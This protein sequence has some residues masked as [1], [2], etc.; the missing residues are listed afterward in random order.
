MRDYGTVLARDTCVKVT[1]EPSLARE[2]GRNDEPDHEIRSAFSALLIP[3]LWLG[4]PGLA[5]DRNG[6]STL[7]EFPPGVG[8]GPYPCPDSGHGASTLA[9]LSRPGSVI[10]FPKFVKGGVDAA[11]GA[12][13]VS[14]D[15]VCLPR[16]E[17]ELGATCPTLF[18][19]ASI[20]PESQPPSPCPDHERVRVRFRWVCPG[21]QDFEQK[22]ICKTT[23]LTCT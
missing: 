5:D 13:N 15:G 4:A 12:G 1:K 17:I 7:C 20:L 23:G 21:I 2:G 14:V 6:F 18:T 10:V 8:S 22:F 19:V 16:T 9:D 11:C 3:G